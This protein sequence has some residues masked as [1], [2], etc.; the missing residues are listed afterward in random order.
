MTYV[1]SKYTIGFTKMAEKNDFVEKLTKNLTLLRRSWTNKDG[2]TSSTYMIRIR[3]PE[4]KSY[5]RKHLVAETIE[6]AK[7][8]AIRIY[9]ESLTA[10]KRG[11][12]ISQERK[13]LPYYIKEYL[14]HRKQDAADGEITTQRY[15]VIEHHLKSL[16]EFWVLHKKLRLDNF[17][18]TYQQEFKTWRGQ[19]TARTTGKLLSSSFKD[20]ELSTHRSLFRWCKDKGYCE[21]VVQIKGYKK[22][23]ANKPFPKSAW[24]KLQA[25]MQQ[26]IKEASNI[27]A[28]WNYIIYYNQI[29][30]MNALGLRV[31]EI[32]NLKWSDLTFRKREDDYTLYI[33]GKSKERTIILPPDARDYLLRLQEFCQKE[34]N[35]WWDETN[36]PHIFTLWKS[37]VMAHFNQQLKRK[38][39]EGAG[40][41]SED[42]QL[43][44]F[45][46]A[47][48]TRKLNEGVNSL[49]IAKFCGTS[50]GMIER[51]YAGL[52]SKDIYKMVFGNIPK[53][54]YA[55]ERKPVSFM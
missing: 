18:A 9:G 49:E 42:Y 19:A 32:K 6:D 13:G 34:N 48:I 16:H 50:V 20:A 17:I 23:K 51:T 5:Y 43:V 46:H 54:R 12:R 38:W 28:K 55:E 14:K 22:V 2:N 7:E 10:L 3:E 11:T 45:R 30:L 29:L 8:E 39:F 41:K 27:R 37:G 4:T 40:L 25:V 1:L 15:E 24:R 35:G 52:V 33:Q 36:D 26:E 21:R 53:Q 47:F 44:S 31:T